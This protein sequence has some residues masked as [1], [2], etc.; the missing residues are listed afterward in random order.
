M[1]KYIFLSILCL[2]FHPFIHAQKLA[3]LG[4]K[5]GYVKCQLLGDAEKGIEG[6]GFHGGFFS[7]LPLQKKM[8]LQAELLYSLKGCDWY[9]RKERNE[10][11]KDY[12]DILR[13]IEIPILF[14]YHYK[15]F[16]M[17]AGPGMGFLLQE[18]HYDGRHF[19]SSLSTP[20]KSTDFSVNLG[21]GYQSDKR[22][23]CGLRYVNSVVPIR[24]EPTKQYNSS[25]LFVIFYKILEHRKNM[26]AN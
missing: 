25:L 26:G 12:F 23:G 9:P 2:L 21:I 8:N 6:E 5:I 20:A 3:L 18:F 19:I 7:Q 13:Y 14:Q 4:V 1:K 16:L 24:T 15:S 11:S 17:E 10:R 22:F